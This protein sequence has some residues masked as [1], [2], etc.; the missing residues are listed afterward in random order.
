MNALAAEFKTAGNTCK[1]FTKDDEPI[2]YSGFDIII[3]DTYWVT[4]EYINSLNSPNRLLVCYDDNALYKYSC[5]VLVNANLHA[6]TLEFRFGEKIPAL[7]LGGEY[8]LLRDEFKNAEPITINK[9]VKNIFM[10]FGGTD[11]RNFTPRAIDILHKLQQFTFHVV[12]GDP[13]NFKSAEFNNIKIYEKPCKISEIMLQCDLAVAAAGSMTYELASLGIP[14]NLITQADNQEKIAQFMTENALMKCIGD[15]T[16]ISDETIF[17]ETLK[18]AEDYKRRL[19]EHERL[20][21]TVDRHGAYNLS[22]K[23][24]ELYNEIIGKT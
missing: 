24:I 5:D 8:A 7:V 22:R 6:K 1:F 18:L 2:D 19:F 3:I 14:S 13:E 15:Y 9:T 21:K 11:L 10:C 4:D 17:N 20:I 23:I 12:V 16:N